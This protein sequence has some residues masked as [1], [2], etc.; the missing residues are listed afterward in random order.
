MGFKSLLLL[1]LSVGFITD[2]NAQEV[3][4]FTG[5]ESIHGTTSDGSK[6]AYEIQLESEMFVF[7]YV[8]QISGDVVVSIL[9]PNKKEIANFDTP[10]R[11]Q[12]KFRFKTESKG[13][14]QIVVT[15]FEEDF[16]DYEVKIVINEPIAITKEG[17]IDQM[18]FEYT[19]EF[20]GAAVGI[21]KDGEIFFSKGYGQAN[22]SYDIPFDTETVTNIGS[23]TKQFTAFG[24]M[25]LVKEGKISLDEKVQTYIPELKEFEYKVTV[26]NL[27]THT[28][29]YREILNLVALSG[30]DL[31][32]GAFIKRS[33]YIEII[34]RQP[35]LQ[36]IPG[37]VFNYNNTGFGLLTVII[38]RVT[39]QSFPEYMKEQ[40]FEPLG[41]K[42]TVVRA[43]QFQIVPN[44]S[45]GYSNGEQGELIEASDL[46]V[47]MGAGG[48][49]TTISDLAKWMSNLQ[50]G[51]IGGMEIIEQMTTPFILEDGSS[52]NYGLG[53]FIDKQAGKKR[54]QHGG[55]DTAH[56][57]FFALYPD[58][59]SGVISVSNYAGFNAGGIAVSASEIFFEDYFKVEEETEP[60]EVMNEEFD[61]ENFSMDRFKKMEGEYALEAAPA[62]ILKFFSEEGE[63]FTQA[64][65]QQ[66][67]KITPTSDSTFTLV[68][69]NAN[70]IFHEGS[71]GEFNALT[72]DQNGLN[73]ANRVTEEPWAPS[74]SD[75]KNYTGTYFS[76]EIETFYTVSWSDSSITVNQRL[77]G[78]IEFS[79]IEEDKFTSSSIVS[80]I[81]FQRDENGKVSA[82]LVS[83][84]R[85]LGVRFEK[86]D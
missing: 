72:L 23:V 3:I 36:N 69:V 79:P 48:I 80:E 17:K 26:R 35:E 77:I 31:N 81:S 29:G 4:K 25:L 16:G 65:G 56:R 60:S 45:K 37:T 46:S 2:I 30:R 52:T 74:E 64:T 12:E 75:I 55:A 38:E 14:Y 47:S 24:I 6:T 82:L 83:N 15:P 9:D 19:D 70:I 44:S 66:K 13:L 41:M 22:L 42:N 58:I 1:G 28:S 62:F 43:E 73:K 39:D 63:F 5:D 68:G 53:L 54:I 78:D 21:V 67:V 51:R 11:G 40:V 10:A 49:Y 85:T 86:K 34:Q 8:D 27:L 84:G 50:T 32:K 18:L 61:A 59:N 76:E 33:E 20:A 57:A 71:N 7:G